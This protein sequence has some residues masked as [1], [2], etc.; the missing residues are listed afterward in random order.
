MG[1]DGSIKNEGDGYAIP[2]SDG[3]SNEG[4]GYAEKIQRI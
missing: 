4:S 2:T 3:I 1:S